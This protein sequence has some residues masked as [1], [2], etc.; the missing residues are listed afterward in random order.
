M[1]CG[2]FEIIS[3]SICESAKLS[4]G[5]GGYDSR[6]LSTICYTHFMFKLLSLSLS[7]S[8]AYA[9]VARM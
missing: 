7:V 1:Y 4:G 5:S 8:M 2:S 9:I 6:P 3:K